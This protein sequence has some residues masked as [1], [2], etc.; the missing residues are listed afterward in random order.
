MR[1]EQMYIFVHTDAADL[2]GEDAEDL[3]RMLQSFVRT[4]RV[5]GLEVN[6]C[7][8][9]LSRAERREIGQQEEVYSNGEEVKTSKILNNWKDRFLRDVQRERSR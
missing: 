8:T 9:K 3:R 6:V 7:K 1:R 4:K 5:V 2:I